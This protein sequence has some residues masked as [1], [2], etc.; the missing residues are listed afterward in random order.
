MMATGAEALATFVAAPDAWDLVLT[1][2][3]MPSLSGVDVLN[4]VKEA[5]PGLPVVIMTGHSDKLTQAADGGL[6]GEVPRPLL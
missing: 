3:T 2:Q 5:R 1:D 4:A 6:V